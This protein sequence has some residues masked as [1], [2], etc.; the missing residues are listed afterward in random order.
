M[1]GANQSNNQPWLVQDVVAV[2]G[3]VHTLPKHP[4]KF[5]PKFDP[6]KKDSREDHIKNFMFFVRLLN[7]EQEDVVSRIFPYTFEGK[8][9]TCYI[10]LSQASITIWN[11]FETTF[12]KKFRDDKSPTTLVLD[13]SRIKMEIKE[14]VKYFNESSLTLMNKISLTSKPTND[15]STEFYSSTLPISMPLFM[16]RDKNGTLEDTFKEAIKVEKELL[17]LKGNPGVEV[18]NDKSNTKSKAT[19][20]KPQEDK[21]D[22]DSMDRE[23]LKGIVK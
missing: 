5:L 18:K 16:K 12:I 15:V 8:V 20:K 10:S 14:K 9:P 1:A 4:K 7:V 23:S 19:L 17:R 6:D 13:I 3:V 2:L 22:Q 21:R 11:T